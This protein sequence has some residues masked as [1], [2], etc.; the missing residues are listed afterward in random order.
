MMKR[1]FAALFMLFALAMPAKATYIITNDPGGVIDDFQEKYTMLRRAGEKVVVD[2]PCLSACTLVFALVP[3]SHV[4]ITPNAV[5]GFHSARLSHPILGE[6]FSLNGTGQM[7][8]QYPRKL[9]AWLTG[10]GWDGTTEHNDLIW[11]DNEDAETFFD[12][13]ES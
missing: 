13:C 4:C 9:R 2:G 3:K 7:W 10:Q 1:L 5:F 6:K 11:M 8:F 12:K